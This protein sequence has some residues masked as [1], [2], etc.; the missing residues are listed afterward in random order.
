VSE[1]AKTRVAVIGARGIGKHHAKW[2]HA[3]G[4]DVCAFGGASPDRLEQTGETLRGLFP[5]EGR[6]YASVPELLERERPDIVDV[7]SPPALHYGH[8]HAA[9]EAGCDVLCE[10]PF[11]YG[12]GRET[13]ELLAQA[14]R[15]VA[16]AR[17]TGRQ[18]GVCT[19]YAVA[20]D[21][22]NALWRDLRGGEPVTAYCGHLASP[23][24]DRAPDPVRVWVDLS[25]HP[26]SVALRLA[27]GARVAWDT[28]ETKFEGYHA[29]A[30]FEMGRP[31]G[32]LLQCR[33][34]TENTQGPPA[35][36]RCFEYNGY[37]FNVEG[38]NDD[39]GVYRARIETPDGVTRRPDMMHQLIRD[40][41]AGEVVSGDEA[42]ASLEVMLGVLDRAGAA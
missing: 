10:K 22:F 12:R 5:F 27:P 42:L 2:W 36:V 13:A 29:E 11:V 21:T 30:S 14:Q 34:V 20:A 6:G 25:P 31:G 19:Q 40:F 15:L 17:E 38:E 8:V 7:C 3:E 33:L 16:L 24:K 1:N 35:H 32:P 4:A 37:A 41:L 26:I 9:L 23:A 28:L 39:A 18:L